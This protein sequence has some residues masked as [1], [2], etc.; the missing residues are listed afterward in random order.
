LSVSATAG[1]RS[2]TVIFSPPS[3]NG[4]AA[5]TSYTVTS[6]P[7]NI[8]RSGASSPIVVTG[9]T[10]GTSYTFTMTA[11]NAIGVSAS[12]SPSNSVVP[13]EAQ[14]GSRAGSKKRSS[15]SND[16]PIIQ[17]SISNPVIQ[18]PSTVTGPTVTNTTPTSPTTQQPGQSSPSFAK[19]LQSGARDTDVRA[20]QRFLN[21]RGFTVAQIGPGS[22]GNETDVFGPATRAALARFQSEN[23]ISPAIGYFGPKTREVVNSLGVGTSPQDNGSTTPTQPA[24]DAEQAPGSTNSSPS[25]AKD[26]QSGARDTDVRALQRFLNARGFTV[27][28][29]GPGS[30]GNETDVFG[31]A[32][33][34][35]LARFQSENGISPAVGYFGPKTREV[36]NSMTA[37]STISN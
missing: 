25:F 21:A 1:D 37:T 26:L 18:T 34:A 33:R 4:G 13:Q 17:P 14:I 19:D 35:A 24:T 7:G 8:T 27:A 6:A 2:A 23:G 22:A 32:T 9:L 12:S 28:Q 10:N 20:L 30:A 3:S 29:I 31:P 11:T 5:I 15:Y 36:V 16:A